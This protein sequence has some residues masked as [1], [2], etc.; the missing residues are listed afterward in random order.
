MAPP[1]APTGA[2]ILRLLPAFL[3]LGGGLGVP[4][5]PGGPSALLAPPLDGLSTPPT[6]SGFLSAPPVPT[7]KAPPASGSTGKDGPPD[8]C[9]H[10]EPGMRCEGG[11]GPG[12]TPPPSA[13]PGSTGGVLGLALAG[14]GGVDFE[15]VTG[16][17]RGFKRVVVVRDA[18]EAAVDGVEEKAP[19]ERSLAVAAEARDAAA[20]ASVPVPDDALPTHPDLGTTAFLGDIDGGEPPCGHKEPGD[21]NGP[22]RNA[23]SGP[24]SGRRR[25]VRR[26]TRC[27]GGNAP[28]GGGHRRRRELQQRRR[29]RTASD[30]AAGAAG[31]NNAK[32]AAQIP[33]ALPT[34][35]TATTTTVAALPTA[36]STSSPSS[37][38]P[39]SL[40]AG[41]K[42]VGLGDQGSPPTCAH[43]QQS[44]AVNIVRDF[45]VEVVIGRWVLELMGVKSEVRQMR[46]GGGG[47]GDGDDGRQAPWS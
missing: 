31:N 38:P 29:R 43:R 17:G 4:T 34:T 7:P 32:R 16:G 41:A 14:G 25:N 1:L 2:R 18:R 35:T 19:V 39:L 6:A 30:D 20:P 8:S 27:D 40:P 5:S 28:P 13:L 11:G 47:G 42:P 10:L 15:A 21:D 37:R 46:C 23:P 9:A 26:Q 36:T 45:V 24:P 44:S 3:L 22:L 33:V 12:G